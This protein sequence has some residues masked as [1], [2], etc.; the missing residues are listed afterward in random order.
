MGNNGHHADGNR[1]DPGEWS[2]TEH[3]R[4]RLLVE[5]AISIARRLEVLCAAEVAAAPKRP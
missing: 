1:V 5:R 4:A 3:E 2:E